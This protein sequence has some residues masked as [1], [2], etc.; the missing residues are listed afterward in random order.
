[1]VFHHQTAI[2]DEAQCK[3]GNTS[4]LHAEKLNWPVKK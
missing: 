3:P 2:K 1:M 4:D